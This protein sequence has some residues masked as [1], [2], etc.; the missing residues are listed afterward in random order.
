MELTLICAVGRNREIGRGGGLIW[1]ISDDLKRFKK[2]TMGHPVVMGRKT[3]ESI[4]FALPGRTNVIVTRQDAYSAEGCEVAG[5]VEDALELAAKS[6]GGEEV[7]IIGGGQLYSELIG[8]ASKLALTVIDDEADDADTW[9]PEY[10]GDFEIA[11]EEGPFTDGDLEYKFVDYE[12][13]P[14]S[15]SCKV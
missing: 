15:S 6:E 9:F 12:R 13:R 5:S 11:H 2:I 10:A 14:A 3:Y 8:K 4:G 1:R 7:F